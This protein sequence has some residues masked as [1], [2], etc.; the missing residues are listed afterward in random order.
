[1]TISSMTGFA[2]AGG[3]SGS[4]TWQWDLRSVN[5]KSL[6]PRFRLPPGLEHLEAAARNILSAF[7][8]RGNIQASLTYTETAAGHGIQ[9]DENALDEA[10]AVAQRFRKLLGGGPPNVEALMGLRGIVE[11]VP[12]P[13]PED[14]AT[15]RDA[16]VLATLS[17]AA[18]QMK[19]SRDAEGE[20]IAGVLNAA[21]ARIEALVVQAIENPSRKSDVIKAR[22]KEQIE[23]L[24]EA[25]KSF[26]TARLHQ[27]AM[28]LATRV[29]VQE[30]IDRLMAHVSAARDLMQRGEAVG[31]KLDFLAQEFNREAN[32]L[33]SKSNDIALTNTGLE[34]KNTIDQFREQLQNIE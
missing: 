14:Y 5:G 2:R 8:K 10:V 34:L 29:D 20:K 21:I 23:R 30:E 18:Q 26:D 24:F 15:E 19:K 31:R 12:R 7:F 16:N 1:M 4:V 3:G 6:E 11:I 22:L 27:E 25:S 9:V 32:T 33:C 28:L 17:D 13:L